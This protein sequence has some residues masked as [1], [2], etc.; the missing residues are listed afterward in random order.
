[1]KKGKTINNISNV[2]TY[3]TPVDGTL[4]KLFESLNLCFQFFFNANSLI[5]I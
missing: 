5:S 3:Q 4:L 1:M 2:L